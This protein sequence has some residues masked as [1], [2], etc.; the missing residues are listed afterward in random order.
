MNEKT[1]P[2]TGRRADGSTPERRTWLVQA[3]RAD[4]DLF[5]VSTDP[6]VAIPVLAYSE[7][8]VPACRCYRCGALMSADEVYEDEVVRSEHGGGT[9]SPA[10]PNVRPVCGRC[11]DWL[12]AHRDR[13]GV[14]G[15]RSARL[16]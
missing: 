6:P 16:I 1:A 8:S 5:V 11:R 12:A 2:V 9:S 4:A 13:A 3:F 14:R 10:R 7:G 15:E